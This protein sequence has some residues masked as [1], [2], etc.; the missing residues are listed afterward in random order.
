MS[1]FN[2]N[3]LGTELQ[4]VTQNNAGIGV[5]FAKK[6]LKLD[7][8][9]DGKLLIISTWIIYYILKFYKIMQFI[10]TLR[11]CKLNIFEFSV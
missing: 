8:E 10:N 5:S 7:T 11:L 1:S 6:S 4:D 9:E 2:L 3:D